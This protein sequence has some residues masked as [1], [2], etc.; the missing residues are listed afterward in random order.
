MATEVERRTADAV[1]LDR[2]LAAAINSRMLQAWP[3]L[4]EQPEGK[5]DFLLNRWTGYH[6]P[7]AQRPQY[8]LVFQDHELIALAHSFA[9]TIRAEDRPIPVLGLAN[10]CVANRAK[11]RGYGRLVV[12]A[13]FDRVARDGFQFCVFQTTPAVEPFYERLGAVRV[14]NRFYNSLGANSSANPF[15][16]PLAMRYPAE[17]AW[18]D[19]PIDLLGPGY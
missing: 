5:I 14:A 1:D 6:G 11:G 19:G 4:R 2:P 9:R 17:G 7:D 8:H 16:E 15:W 18:P 3:H 13:A 12:E 10:V